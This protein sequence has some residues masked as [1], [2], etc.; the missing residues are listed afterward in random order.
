MEIYLHNANILTV[1]YWKVPVILYLK[2]SLSRLTNGM[3][4]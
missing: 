4:T 1:I 3:F 2:Q